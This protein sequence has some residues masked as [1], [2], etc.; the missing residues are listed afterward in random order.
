[1][2]PKTLSKSREDERK[3]ATAQRQAMTP[4]QRKGDESL[5]GPLIKEATCQAA[6]TTEGKAI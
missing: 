4:T 1:M 6:H 3:T 5:P 2:S